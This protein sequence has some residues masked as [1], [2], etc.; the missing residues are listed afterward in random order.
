MKKNELQSKAVEVLKAFNNS[1]STSRLYPPEAPQVTAAV[2]RGYKVI[3]HYL[4]Q[5]RRLE[6]SILGGQLYLGGTP[7]LQDVLDSFPN[8]HI[9]RQLKIL[10]LASLTVTADMDRF[11]F[12]QLLVVFQASVAKIKAN[13]GGLEYITGLGL[14]DYFSTAESSAEAQSKGADKA[15]REKNIL[16]VRPELV[17]CLLGKDKRPL[18][19]EDLK[20]RIVV[21]ESSVSILAATIARILQGIRAKKKIVAAAEFSKVLRTAETL[22]PAKQQ[23]VVTKQ[24]AEL[25]TVNL[26]DSALCV[27]FCQEFPTALGRSLYRQ[28]V[29]GLSGNRI[30]QVIVVFR[31]QIS[32][33]KNKGAKTPEVQ[34]LGKSLLSLMN[35]DKGKTFLSAEKAKTIIHEG[36][37]ERTKKRLNSGISSILE[38][39][40]QILENEEF[41]SALP[42]GML[43]MHKGPKSE[44]VPR[45]MNNLIKYL[46]S[47]KEKGGKKILTCL[48]KIGNDF[49]HEGCIAQAQM[50]AEPLTLV[51]QRASLSPQRFEDTLT[52]LQKL[53]RAC[54]K[55][56]D[57]EWGDKILM[58]F[59]QMR[60]GQIEKS[61][62]LKVIVGHVQDRGIDRASLPL[63][64]KDCLENPNDESLSY[65]LVLQGPIAIRFLVDA[66]IET[67]GSIDRVKIIDLLTYNT[68]Y[69]PAIVMERL[70]NHMPWYGKRNLIK[71]LG[72]TG[73]PE[74]AE[75]V[76]GFLKHS[77]FRVQRETFLCI[78]K[79]GGLQRKKYFLEA[80]EIASEPISIQ[81]VE[82]FAAFC[83]QEVAGRLAVLLDEYTNF[84][85]STREPL[86]LALFNTL[87]R[88]PC[89]AS[90]RAVQSFVASKG[91]KSTKNL[92]KK[93]WDSA[94]KSLHFLKNDLQARKK[95]H[96]QASQ[97]RKVALQQLSKKSKTAVNQRVVTGLPE[98]QTIRNLLSKGE[99]SEGVRHLMLLI[100]RTARTRN[101]PQAEQLRDW[102][103]DIDPGEVNNILRAGEIIA[104]EKIAVIDRSHLEVWSDLY[105][106]LSTEEFSEVF[107]HLQHRTYLTEERVVDQ[108]EEQNA[109]FFVNRGEVKIHYMDDGEDY[110]IAT[111]KSGEI[112]GADAFFEP[113]IWTISVT[114]IGDSEISLLSVDVL[115]R[116][117]TEHPQLEEK[118][119][120]FCQRFE[121]LENLIVKNSRDRR[122][123]KRHQVAREIKA[124]LIDIRGRS[125]GIV[126]D[127]TLLDVSQGGL[128]YTM[129][130]ENKRNLRQFLGRK[131][132]LNLPIEEVTDSITT[133]TGE[134]VSVKSRKDSPGQY[135]VH[136]KFE[137]LLEKQLL[138]DVIQACRVDPEANAEV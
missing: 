117:S 92:S 55:G 64:L 105:D 52:F 109:L 31:E 103:V 8:L 61:D 107:E 56:G 72:E 46:G 90:L 45:V 112:F 73:R 29:S 22:I 123:H 63:F 20:K 43:E 62:E 111:M 133:V 25:L 66:L 33:V 70:P 41:I 39:D 94:E 99:M 76:I 135:S 122:V 37:R 30:G 51:A 24:L 68:S 100:E 120:T 21:T 7:L 59:H 96:L 49:L 85:E 69:L 83:D 19:I 127:V 78:Y 108:G 2:D 129:E 130:F 93:V 58:L 137:K 71:L 27:L 97:L 57:K 5:Y 50:L 116:W 81:I 98:E 28:L 75:N 32:R 53:M 125:T 95:K 1:I 48:L 110:L 36:E 106:I 4:H 26:K 14:T 40:Y 136:M 126:D 91:E 115:H 35:T 13:G 134:I 44:Y 12:N 65:R 15:Q 11:T 6:F 118:L 86:L 17:S 132:R 119:L 131:V 87:G 104:Q 80:L 42:E 54:W 23:E 9:Y 124:N 77:D 113:S 34:L 102:L 74:D 18:V 82:A 114:S 10:D 60:S 101:F 88:C 89:N 128:A 79:I 3:K 67:E 84:S 121:R 16:K 38:G 138:Y 47:R